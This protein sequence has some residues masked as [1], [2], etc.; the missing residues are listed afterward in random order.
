GVDSADGAA[1][2]AQGAVAADD[3]TQTAAE[4]AGCVDL[5]EVR[6][7]VDFTKRGCAF[8]TAAA[9]DLAGVGEQVGE[10]ALQVA[11]LCFPVLVQLGEE[12]ARLDAAVELGDGA[13]RAD[14]FASHEVLRD[15]SAVLLF[16]GCVQSVHPVRDDVPNRKW[17]RG[18]E[19][20]GEFLC[21]HSTGGRVIS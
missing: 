8:T 9:A 5:D 10:E 18:F 11:E 13:A 17:R 16:S 6:T 4:G 2:F 15:W 7:A 20:C 14:Q 19:R 21:L 3:F 12:V 1:P